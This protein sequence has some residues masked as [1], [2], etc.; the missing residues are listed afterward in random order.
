MKNL[1]QQR[2]K[3]QAVE[4]YVGCLKKHASRYQKCSEQ[5]SDYVEEEYL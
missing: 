5:N 2:L 4:F 1:V 3:S